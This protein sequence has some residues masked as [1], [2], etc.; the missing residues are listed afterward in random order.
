M[1][2]DTLVKVLL[3]G[4]LVLGATSVCLFLAL[5]S[6]WYYWRVDKV[7]AELNS[8]YE[9]HRREDLVKAVAERDRVVDRL[10]GR[11]RFCSGSCGF[12]PGPDLGEEQE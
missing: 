3:L 11:I 8:I 6:A 5:A 7:E 2:V 1:S 10:R 12:P 9:K 4:V